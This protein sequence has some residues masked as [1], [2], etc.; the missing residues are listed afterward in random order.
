MVPFSSTSPRPA[1]P[2]FAVVASGWYHSVVGQEGIKDKQRAGS[3][4]E[5]ALEASHPYSEPVT[6]QDPGSRLCLFKGTLQG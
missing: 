4:L 1:L 5:V 6:S 2:Q 3:N